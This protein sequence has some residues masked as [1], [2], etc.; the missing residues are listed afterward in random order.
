[1]VRAHLTVF[2]FRRDLFLLEELVQAS[3]SILQGPVTV[4]T[5][6]EVH[7]L[8]LKSLHEKQGLGEN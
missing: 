8:R 3:L 5:G 4:E 1:M 7:L 2:I 6:V